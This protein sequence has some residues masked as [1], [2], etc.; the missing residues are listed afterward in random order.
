VLD[1]ER[2]HGL[3]Q[4]ILLGSAGLLGEAVEQ[5]DVLRI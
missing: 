5:L 1:E 4:Q 3:A 2:V